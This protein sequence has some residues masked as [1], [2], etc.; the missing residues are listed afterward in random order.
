MLLSIQHLD[1]EIRYKPGKENI[2]AD[3]FSRIETVPS[4][5]S[6]Q[7]NSIKTIE[8]NTNLVL[9][10]KAKIYEK[11]T[12]ETFVHFGEST[13][14]VSIKIKHIKMLNAYDF[15]LE[16]QKDIQIQ[17]IF[18]N[19]DNNND[20][21]YRIINNVL[22][23]ISNNPNRKNKRIVVPQHLRQQIIKE[24]HDKT[25]SGH[26]GRNKTISR[27][28]KKFFW[29]NMKNEIISYVDSCLK[30]QKIK[31]HFNPRQ[32][33]QHAQVNKPFQMIG[34]DV[35]GPMTRTKDGNLYIIAATCYFSKYAITKATKDFTAYTTA[36]FIFEDIICKYGHVE[37]ILTDQGRN[38]EA[39]L[40]KELCKLLGVEK[41]R[42]TSYHPKAAGEIERFN[43]SIK[44]MIACYVNQFHDDW[45]QYLIQLTFAYNTSANEST[46]ISPYKVIFGRDETTIYDIDQKANSNIKPNSYVDEIIKNKIKINEIVKANIN[47][48]QQK[49]DKY[50]KSSNKYTYAVND[51]VLVTNE[52]MKVGQTKKFVEKFRG[53]Y[54][55]IKIFDNDFKLLELATNKSINVHYDRLKPFKQR[56]ISNNQT[57]QAPKTTS[58]IDNNAPLQQTNSSNYN[59]R[60]RK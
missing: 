51:L 39:D 52:V 7:I 50:Y 19:I 56:P 15:E 58:S 21:K 28:S 25:L 14:S 8:P 45:D 32:K 55:I 46:R 33:L 10:N 49:Q 17:A 6:I 26:L 12:K 18:K 48:A 16:Q 53:P 30:C 42:T 1:Y 22:M 35:A 11:A 4:T 23:K 24:M 57:N 3:F 37:I 41:L 43:K 59:F 38:F 27:V 34:I 31:K 47:K 2:A 5:E 36:K 9:S 13:D 29:P 20:Y 60:K 54:K 44:T 40:I